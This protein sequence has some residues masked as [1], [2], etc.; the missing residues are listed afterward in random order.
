M[1]NKQ[2]IKNILIALNSN[3]IGFFKY[4]I[5][6]KELTHKV[7]ELESCGKIIFDVYSGL[8]KVGK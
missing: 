4:P 3:F 5:G 2:E 1:K 8:W 6:N 7:K